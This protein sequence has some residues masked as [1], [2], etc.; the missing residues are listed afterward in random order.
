[1]ALVDAAVARGGVDERRMG[2]VGGSYGGFMTLWVIGNTDRFRA[3]CTQRTVSQMESMIWSDFGSFLDEELG[4]FPWE[5]PELYR[6]RSP[7]LFA[8]RMRT[9][10][11]ITQGLDDQ[12]TPPDQGERVFVTLSRMGCPVELLLFPG[13]DHDLSRKGRPAQRTARLDAIGEW[14]ARHLG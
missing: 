7:I 6:R 4:A 1:M 8:P 9:P 2:V 12:R 10:L 13:A 11:L 3:A 14:F 5:D